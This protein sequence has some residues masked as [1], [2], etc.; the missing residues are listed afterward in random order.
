MAG[1][2]IDSNLSSSQ[3]CKQFSKL[4]CRF[5]SSPAKP[6]YQIGPTCSKKLNFIL[7]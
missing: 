5:F 7:Y 4:L 2:E 1:T 6:Y 3:I